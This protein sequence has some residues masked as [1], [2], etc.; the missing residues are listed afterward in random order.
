VVVGSV[1]EADLDAYAREQLADFEVPEE[2]V[3]VDA[4]PETGA[5]KLDRDALASEYGR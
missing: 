2:Y 5:G 4:L 1:S 3:F